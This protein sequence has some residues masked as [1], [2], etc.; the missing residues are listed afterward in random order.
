MNDLLDTE[1]RGQHGP[2]R[3]WFNGHSLLSQ[4]GP[5]KDEEYKKK[6]DI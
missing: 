6:S 5:W 3:F 2:K 4:G 1:G